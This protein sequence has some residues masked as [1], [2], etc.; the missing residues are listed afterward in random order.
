M[1][2]ARPGIFAPPQVLVAASVGAEYAA[3]YLGRINDIYGMGKVRGRVCAC[4]RAYM[5]VCMR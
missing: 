2:C 5:Y 1:P 4:V 3:P